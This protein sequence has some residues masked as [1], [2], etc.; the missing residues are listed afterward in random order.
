MPTGDDPD[1][2]LVYGVTLDGEVHALSTTAQVR[3]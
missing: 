2:G 3:A 1:E